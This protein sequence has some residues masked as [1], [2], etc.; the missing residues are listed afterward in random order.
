MSFVYEL[1]QPKSIKNLNHDNSKYFI[2]LEAQNVHCMY[3]NVIHIEL[4]YL[5]NCISSLNG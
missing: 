2:E 4:A 1:M 5:K 3:A